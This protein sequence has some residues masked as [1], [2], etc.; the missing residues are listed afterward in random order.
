MASRH[1][2]CPPTTVSVDEREAPLVHAE[3]CGVSSDYLP[4]CSKRSC[5]VN[6]VSN[7]I[8]LAAF[9]AECE[10]A[11]IAVESIE[12]HDVV[13]NGCGWIFNYR[14]TLQGWAKLSGEP[15]EDANAE[16]ESPESEDAE[17][18]ESSDADVEAAE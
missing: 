7:A 8:K 15:I 6:P 10:E 14:A 4:V 17:S 13:L 3:G 18:E 2:G 11:D 1:D 5:N 16:A 9:E 12:G